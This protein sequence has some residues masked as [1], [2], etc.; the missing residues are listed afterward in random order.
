M[1]LIAEAAAS[2]AVEKQS[3]SLR[4]EMQSVSETSAEFMATKVVAQLQSQMREMESRLR[5][6]LSNKIDS[7]IRQNLGM[8]R[9]DH[10]Q[11]HRQIGEAIQGYKSI[12]RIIWTNI[13]KAV[14]AIGVVGFLGTAAQSDMPA[15]TPKQTDRPISTYQ[16]EGDR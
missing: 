15:L 3:A 9:D 14:G 5:V 7:S 4:S 6:E 8:D 16:I 13:I 2:K 1:Q 10:V 11:Q 12:N